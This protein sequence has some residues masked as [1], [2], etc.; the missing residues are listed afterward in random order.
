MVLSLTFTQQQQDVSQSF[1]A[2]TTI[3]TPSL[4]LFDFESKHIHQ[5][6]QQH[7]THFNRTKVAPYLAK[8]NNANAK[9]TDN[10]A[11]NKDETP[12]TTKRQSFAA[13]HGPVWARTP[14]A[15]MTRQMTDIL[16]Q[17]TPHTSP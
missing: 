16:P 6:H 11:D 4:S 17:A 5:P 14:S 15:N 12:A 7:R 3:R 10:A 2:Q 13:L 9:V 8:Y 1:A